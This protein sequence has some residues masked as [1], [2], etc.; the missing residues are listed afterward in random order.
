MMP[1]LVGDGIMVAGDAAAFCIV[2]GINLEGINLAVQ[3]GVLAGQAA[4]QAHQARNFTKAGL[5]LYRQLLEESFVLKDLKLYRRTPHMLHNDRI[6]SHYPEM[7]CGIMDEI[8]R[9]DGTPKDNMTSLLL[10]KVKE[11]VGL[12]NLMADVYGGWR[13]L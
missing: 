2:T 8:Y 5:G 9:I 6:F 7:L 1:E 13:A 4:I 3:S 12:K 11:T 10:R